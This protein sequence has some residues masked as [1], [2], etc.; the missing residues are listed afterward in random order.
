MLS[1]H[2]LRSAPAD[3]KSRIRPFVKADAFKAWRQVA[4][5]L[6]V[7]VLGWLL[8]WWGLSIHYGLTLLGCAVGAIGIARLF[9]IQHD[10]GHGSFLASRWQ[11]DLLGFVC[12][13]LSQTP[14]H[15]WRKIHAIHHRE[16]GSLGIGRSIGD[17]PLLT[18][19]EYL[20][21]SPLQR[22]NYRIMRHPAFVLG[23]VPF[24]LFF[25]IQRLPL[26]PMFPMVKM[27]PFSRAERYSIHATNLGVILYAWALASLIG[28][29]AWFVIYM[30]ML[31]MV[32]TLGVFLFFVQHQFEQTYW[33]EG[34]PDPWRVAM[35]GSSYFCLPRALQ[36]CIGHTGYHHLHHLSVR[37]PNYALP[38]CHAADALWPQAPQLNLKQAWQTFDYTLWDPGQQKLVPFR[39]LQDPV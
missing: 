25:V 22:L 33:S 17:F 8:A 1:E 12:G 26:L 6:G 3:W 16:A 36:W 15:C 23:I 5:S 35:Q 27:V 30:P 18:V 39:A 14:Y 28:W 13:I 10:C 32:S 2:P 11:R 31:L 9:S 38:A 34:P 7:Y 24:L 19:P 29:Q 20:A 4:V 21:L 37:I